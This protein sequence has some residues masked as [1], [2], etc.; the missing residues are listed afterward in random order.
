MSYKLN[1]QIK[2]ATRVSLEIA[3]IEDSET[4]SDMVVDGIFT[5]YTALVCTTVALK[6]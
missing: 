6:I 2:T 4:E 3:V 1:M 5:Q